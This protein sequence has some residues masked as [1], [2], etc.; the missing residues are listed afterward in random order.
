MPRT[1]PYIFLI[2]SYNLNATPVELN[3]IMHITSACYICKSEITL[4]EGI[5]NWV[6]IACFHLALCY[7]YLDWMIWQLGLSPPACCIRCTMHHKH[8]C[9][10]YFGIPPSWVRR[11]HSSRKSC[12]WGSVTECYYW[13]KSCISYTLVSVVV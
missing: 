6:T 1:S 11:D 12:Y 9:T 2:C 4:A 13:I 3:W 8:I 5:V 7:E 10:C